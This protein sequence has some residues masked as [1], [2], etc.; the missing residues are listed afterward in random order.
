MLFPNY[1][2]GN[3]L[4]TPAASRP[5]LTVSPHSPTDVQAQ[6]DGSDG[7]AG[8]EQVATQPLD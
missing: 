8:Q 4:I 6:V 7:D 2:C 1:V 3:E 5:A